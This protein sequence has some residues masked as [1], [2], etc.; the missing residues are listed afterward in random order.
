MRPVLLGAAVGL[1]FALSLTRFM[2]TLLY[3]VTAADPLTFT[4]IVAVL[5]T[6]CLGAN[7]IP[8]L[9]ASRVDPLV[10]LRQE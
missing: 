4:G 7:L 9:R 3:G 1:I 10:A 6:V 5:M 8:A 2:Q